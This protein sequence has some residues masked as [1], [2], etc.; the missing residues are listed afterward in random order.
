[1]RYCSPIV[2]LA[3]CISGVSLAVVTVGCSSDSKVPQVEGITRE[4]DA[5]LTIREFKQ[6]DPGLQRFFDSA[7]GY[8]V[9]PTI[10]KGGL[11]ITAGGGDGVVYEKDKV[12]GYASVKMLNV[13][14]AVGGRGFSEIIFF[15]DPADLAI[16]KQGRMEFDA[17]ASAVAVRA[18]TPGS[19][20]YSRGVAVFVT[21]E[22]GLMVDASVG[23]QSFRFFPK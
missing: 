13:G 20:D 10:G 1:M 21:D 17:N 15:K 11:V 14:A 8:A 19:A 7:S 4:Q 2:P 9:F 16:F 6:V 12:V 18:G 22:K 23:G 5:G 3:L